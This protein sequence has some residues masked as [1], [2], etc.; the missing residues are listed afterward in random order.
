MRLRPNRCQLTLA[1]LCLLSVLPLTAQDEER[2]SITPA[3]ARDE[4]EGPGHGITTI[5]DPS[6]GNGLDWCL[7]H[8]AKSA[9]NEITAPRIF[10]Y[11]V[12]GQGHDGPFT[13]PEQAREWVRDIAAQG[14]DGIKF[15][16]YR[17]DIMEAAIR[18]A[19]EHDLETTCH[20]AQLAVTRVNVL[21]S[22]GWGL[23]SMEH[24]YGLPEALFEDRLIQDYPAD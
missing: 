10:A 15:F 6:C 12:F 7:E 9:T 23:T 22:A 11:P 18:E 4:G 8:K 17:P 19:N 20:H 14:A 5:R 13:A 3:P 16:G 1:L 24:W 21:D 2:E